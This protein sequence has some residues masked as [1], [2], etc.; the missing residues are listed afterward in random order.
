MNAFVLSALLAVG[1]GPAQASIIPQVIDRLPT[2]VVSIDGDWIVLAAEK[3][4]Q[5]MGE[6]MYTTVT[7]K[8][9]V[10]TFASPPGI[11]SGTIDKT[12]LRKPLRL[13]F[14]P[15]HTIRVLEV[16]GAGWFGLFTAEVKSGVYVLTGDYLAIA[17]HD[18]DG[19]AEIRTRGERSCTIF[20]QRTDVSRQNGQRK[21]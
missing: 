20:L 4:G 9:N 14:G 12:D 18:E 6:V 19:P 11:L 21:P 15:D 16:T 13:G 7:V 8:D 5:P 17:V 1:G 3:Y 2:P 10:M